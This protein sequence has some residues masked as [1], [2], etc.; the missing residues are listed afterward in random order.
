MGANKVVRA[1]LLGGVLPLMLVSQVQKSKEAKMKAAMAGGK[2]RKKKW[3]KGKA[4]AC[5]F[6]AICL[7]HCHKPTWRLGNGHCQVKE[8][9][10]N[11]VMFD[12]ARSSGIR[13]MY[14]G[15]LSG[16]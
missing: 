1:S 2:S 11:L 6:I 14:A 8:K 16:D 9:L 12:K 7:A 10:A 4:R 5:L 15:H 3:A 13:R